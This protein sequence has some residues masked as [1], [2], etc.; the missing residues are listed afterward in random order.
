MQH[1]PS[2]SKRR[3]STELEPGW[4]DTSPISLLRRV[5]L[6]PCRQGRSSP[7]NSAGASPRLLLSCMQYSP[8]P[9]PAGSLIHSQLFGEVLRAQVVS[10][11]S[12]RAN[13]PLG[14]ARLPW[15]PSS[16][17]RPPQPRSVGWCS[18]FSLPGMPWP[19][20]ALAKNSRWQVFGVKSLVQGGVIQHTKLKA[21]G[22]GLGVAH[23]PCRLGAPPTLGL[24]TLSKDTNL[25]SPAVH[26]QHWHPAG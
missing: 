13:R 16:K 14:P 22:L 20:R 3:P 26:P 4:S 12:P 25:V 9:A 17:Y 5:Y 19:R 23:M 10:F 21:R 11:Y 7:G 6:M 1:S 18:P 24:V 2:G 8:L 15:S